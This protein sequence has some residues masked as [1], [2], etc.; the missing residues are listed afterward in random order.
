M[1]ARASIVFDMRIV[2]FE[3]SMYAT[4]DESAQNYNI[5]NRPL[6]NPVS[7]LI[8]PARAI[9]GVS[10]YSN[11][12]S[13]LHFKTLATALRGFS[14]ARTGMFRLREREHAGDTTASPA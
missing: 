5:G 1:L 2:K 7:V 3:R 4:S 11:A 9:A 14:Q 8:P 12:A 13:A 6:P 10:T